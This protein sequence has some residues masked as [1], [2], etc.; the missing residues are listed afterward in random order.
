MRVV[1]IPERGGQYWI[2]MRGLSIL[3]ITPG[4]ALDDIEFRLGTALW[5][6]VPTRGILA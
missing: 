5:L 3:R 1:R 6:S 4:V 2:D